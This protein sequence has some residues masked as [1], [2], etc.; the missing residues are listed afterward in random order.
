MLQVVVWII[1]AV[2]FSYG[3][4]VGGNFGS[5][6][7]GTS[8]YAA[9]L[10]WID[11]IHFNRELAGY[12]LRHRGTF[13]EFMAIVVAIILGW[14]F[15]FTLGG[16][17]V[18]FLVGLFGGR[19][20][21]NRLAWGG[22][23][24]LQEVGRRTFYLGMLNVI[25]TSGAASSS[26]MNE[27]F[28]ITARQLLG[29]LGYRSGR[30]ITAFLAEG[31][32]AVT[33][34]DVPAYVANLPREWQQRLLRDALR[35]A[36]S[37]LP[38]DDKKV[39]LIQ[40]L[41]DLSGI[42]DRSLLAQYDRR[43]AATDVTRADWLKELDLKPGATSD[44]VDA[45][46]RRAVKQYHPDRLYDVPAHVKGLVQAK[47]VALNAAY[48]G[49]KDQWDNSRP[50]LFRDSNDQEVTITECAQT[51]VCRCWICGQSNRLLGYAD[52]NSARCGECHALLG[53]TDR[54]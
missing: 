25:V 35:I 18:G 21:S 47:M 8:A 45:A 20:L 43:F 40:S 11:V 36:Y 9:C 39:Q 5:F 22:Q 29:E 12:V 52:L 7:G 17:V 23:A 48:D 19:W 31:Q 42:S 24:Y 15:T 41:L 13:V 34:G 38:A 50:Y 44:E 16:E 28:Q 10:L 2:G 54:S 51:F 26:R 27:E 3:A 46:Y 33:N 6:V 53:M 30:D 37:Q 32:Q 4:L 1:V 14:H 49:L